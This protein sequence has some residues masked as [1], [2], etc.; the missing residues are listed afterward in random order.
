MAQVMDQ[1]FAVPVRWQ[2]GTSVD[3]EENAV[4]SHNILAV[5]H[6]DNIVVVTDV[7]H[8]SRALKEFEAA[9]F[10]V[11]PAAIG[12]ALRAPLTWQSFLPDPRA[13]LRSSYVLHELLGLGWQRVMEFIASHRP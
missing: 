1:D 11:T 12:Y 13:Y 6:I 3:T 2:E 9:G 7:A 5:E 10:K 8:M 4:L